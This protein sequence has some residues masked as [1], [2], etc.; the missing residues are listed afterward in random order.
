MRIY[1]DMSVAS[2][3]R[4]PCP[5][6]L[7]YSMWGGGNRYHCAEGA[8]SPITDAGGIG[9]SRYYW[10]C[11]VTVPDG[12]GL[13]RGLGTLARQGRNEVGFV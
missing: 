12:A 13:P 3:G 1:A 9:L 11:H 8:P 4:P 5:G 10:C 2:L 6:I 7:L